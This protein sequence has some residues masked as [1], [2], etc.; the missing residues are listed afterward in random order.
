VDVDGQIHAEPASL[1]VSGGIDSV[2]GL[3]APPPRPGLL[4]ALDKYELIREIGRGGMGVVLLAQ[5]PTRHNKLFAIKIV[6]PDIAGNP[7]AVHRFLVEARHMADLAHPHVLPV[8]EVSDRR[9]GCYFIMPYMPG[10]S[11]TGK[12]AA[13]Q[14]LDRATTLRV[15]I[16]VAKALRFA[17]DKGI[18]HRDLKPDNVMIDEQG[19]PLL[20]DFGLARTTFNDS[21]VDVRQSRREGT[22]PYMP[23]EIAR[24]EAGDTRC[25][26][27]SF[28][29]L[30]Y[31]MLTGKPPYG[32]AL[33]S[34]SPPVLAGPPPAIASVNP[35]APADLVA[36]ADGAMH[37]E[38]R[39]R[40]ATM[41]DAL[42]DLE[43]AAAGR[44]P[45]GPHPPRRRSTWRT[46]VLTG[47]AVVLLV[48]LA[49][50]V[51]PWLSRTTPAPSASRPIAQAGSTALIDD[52]FDGSELDT[53]T[54]TFDRRSDWDNADSPGQGASNVRLDGGELVL[55]SY[56]QHV[57]GFTR[58]QAGWIDT[59]IDLKQLGAATL[60]L[61]LR[62]QS[63]LGGI[64]VF[65][66][67]GTQPYRAMDATDPSIAL[68][69]L[70]PYE[71]PELTTGPLTLQAQFC[72]QTGLVLVSVSDDGG[73]TTRLIDAGR[74]SYWKLRLAAWSNSSAG[75]DRAAAMLRVDH[76]KVTAERLPTSIAGW[77]TG[78]LT[79]RPIRNASVRTADARHS[80][81]T[82]RDGSFA[83]PIAPGRHKLLID[84]P[85][86]APQAMDLQVSADS[87]ARADIRLVPNSFG[88]GDV[89][90]SIALGSWHESI[91]SIEV[92]AGQV[93]YVFQESA[94]AYLGSPT[95]SPD[96]RSLAGSTKVVELAD[97]VGA[98]G[99]EVVA[100]TG[101]TRINGVLY[102][103]SHYPGRIFRIDP[104]SGAHRVHTLAQDWAYGLAFDGERLWYV[105]RDVINKHM[106]LHA[107][108]AQTF[109]PLAELTSRDPAVRTVAYGRG[110]LWVSND[111]GSVYEIDPAAALSG[112]T[113]DAGVVRT[114]AGHYQ[115]LSFDESDGS[116][117][118]LDTQADMVCK[119]KVTD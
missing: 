55:E 4:G 87:W 109:A 84:S 118:G 91:S 79:N 1:I 23:P 14:P 47:A 83:M 73:T 12:L 99:R 39:D 40:Y 54:W 17:H 43:S 32:G 6:R 51:V 78:E 25:D 116:L 21:I 75:L 15:A 29:A 11:L 86:Y 24:G 111:N 50:R 89:I 36:I 76:A 27:Y 102:G 108:D 114:F 5:D 59:R 106:D 41:A 52:G 48:L 105:E 37:R 115:S 13:G 3:I 20:S 119:I 60:E 61:K 71:I 38:L 68:W 58:V 104:A 35:D 46:T 65:L 95:L 97:A 90:Q 94:H 67:E 96:G 103:L 42:D 62:G 93:R 77:V 63:R 30:L 31:E 85:R 33:D 100:P 22:L 10:G 9:E 107:I 117:W 113:M 112:G 49:Q 70:V 16:G 82:E 44:R 98:S 88:Y 18:I 74:L 92:S 64:A 57:G 2:C 8:L 56:A 34:A 66:S 53:A 45:V 72:P 26:I 28:G 19:E 101:L 69:Q 110:R 81:H 7:R 80:A